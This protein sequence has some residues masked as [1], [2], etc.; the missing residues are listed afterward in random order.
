MAEDCPWFVINIDGCNHLKF[1]HLRSEER[2]DTDFNSLLLKLPLLE[3][4]YLF[5]CETLKT[6]K[7]L[8]PRIKTVEIRLEP[9]CNLELIEILAPKS[10]KLHL[11]DTAR[12]GKTLWDQGDRLWQFRNH[13]VY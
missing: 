5:F 1:L 12:K 3:E 6:I 8:N 4:L 9:E 13:S 7:I 11:Y 10:E 2:S